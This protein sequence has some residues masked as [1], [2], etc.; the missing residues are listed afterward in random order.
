VEVDGDFASSIVNDRG[1]IRV[2]PSFRHTHKT[3][4]NV[5]FEWILVNRAGLEPAT[6]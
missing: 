1:K 5:I 2:K 3:T 6:R 4:I